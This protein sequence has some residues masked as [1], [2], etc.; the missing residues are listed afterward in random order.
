MAPTVANP[1]SLATQPLPP[2]ATFASPVQAPEVSQAAPP[3]PMTTN[4]VSA[5]QPPA[6]TPQPEPEPA[7]PQTSTPQTPP[8]GYDIASL[9]SEYEPET[10]SAEEARAVESMIVA[11]LPADGAETPSMAAQDTEVK[12]DIADAQVTSAIPEVSRCKN[13][14]SSLQPGAIF[15]TECG[16][17][18]GES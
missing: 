6:P 18:V 5:E 10:S 13:C 3:E 9:W 1:V 4:A 12:P 15:C 8:F 17:R 2:S 11:A 7:T 16:H 14:G